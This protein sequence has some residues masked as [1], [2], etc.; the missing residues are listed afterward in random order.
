MFLLAALIQP[1]PMLGF[2]WFILIGL[3]LCLGGDVFIA[4]RHEKMFHLG[5]SS[6]LVGHLFYMIGF[7]T[8][9]RLSVWTW[10]GTLLVLMA[11]SRVYRWLRAHLGA[12][13]QPVLG[14]II[15]ITVML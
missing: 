15:V 5:L 2:Y 3:L 12:M 9:A 6:F 10:W 7:F 14:Y 8:T 13:D 1:Q 11:S 4:L